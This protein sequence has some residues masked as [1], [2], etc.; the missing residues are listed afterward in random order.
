MYA[1]VREYIGDSDDYTARV[2]VFCQDHDCVEV[3]FKHQ[4]KDV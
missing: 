2:L 3:T 4:I 1:S